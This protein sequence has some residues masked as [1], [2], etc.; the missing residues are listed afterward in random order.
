MIPEKQTGC[1]VREPR[2]WAFMVESD[3][4]HYEQCTD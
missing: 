1:H 3:L 4:E 2:S